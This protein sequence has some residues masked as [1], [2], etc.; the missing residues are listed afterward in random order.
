MGREFSILFQPAPLETLGPQ[1]ILIVD[2][3]ARMRTSLRL[4]L[5]GPERIIED[6]ATGAEALHRLAI[7]DVDLLL[8]DLRLGD[9]PGVDIM[10]TISR[11]QIATMV[12]V[13]SADDNIDSA[14]AALRW[15]VFGYVR[16]PYQPETIRHSVANALS[17]RRLEQSNALMSARLEQSERLHRYLVEQAPDIVY[18]LDDGG[19]FNFINGRVEALLGFG[20]Q[21][22][23]GQH[24]LALVH[25]GDREKAKNAFNERRNGGRASS[26]VELRL[27]CKNPVGGRTAKS[28]EN[29]FITVTL[30]AMGIWSELD[31]EG[32]ARRFIG[33][34]GVARDISDRK[35]AEDLI[36][37]Q[38]HHDLLTGLP[39]RQLFKDHVELAIARAE[40]SGA[41][42]AVMFLDL[43][44]FKLIN[45]TFGH[46][47]G[48]RLLRDLA[49]RLS[50]CRRKGD[51]LARLGGDEFVLLVDDLHG[52]EDVAAIA[53]KLLTEVRRPFDIEGT[54]FRATTS[55]GVAYFPDDGHDV[56]ALIT[57]ADIA[58]YQ[59]KN[60]GKNGY[61]MFTADM[62]T[63]FRKRIG[64]ENDLRRAL[65]DGELELYY[66]PCVSVG[67][68]CVVALEALVRW[69]HPEHGL[70]N[71]TNFVAIAEEVGLIHAIGDF[72]VESAC[73]QLRQWHDTGFKHIRVAINASPRE[74]ERRD[75]VERVLSTMRKFALP[76]N[77]LE[78]EITENTLISDTEGTI[79]RVK[80]LRSA[81]VRIAIDD[82][83]TRYS[84]LNYLQRFPVHTLKIDQCFVRDLQPGRPD[85]PII[86]AIVAI[87]KGF[88]I[89]L[90]SEGVETEFQR[91]ALARMGCDEMQGYLFS[92]PLSP[93]NATD[94]MVGASADDTVP[95]G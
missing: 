91:D 77:A 28:F 74:F 83:G 69:R 20:R 61:Q 53:E 95:L 43:D 64:L 10:E 86:H 38:A 63:A 24:Y 18:T 94:Y 49:A 17:R 48:D 50:Q 75:F 44:R 27:I 14:I 90:V 67:R 78:V 41:N 47:W 52:R 70:L 89:H 37:Y 34:Y 21:E 35:E 65:V 12:I 62:N 73:R 66:Q 85:S 80:Q 29:R 42:L 55:I 25:E 30:S 40:R 19:R 58:M 36:T 1:R 7:G 59:M 81:G 46:L 16:K 9:I 51:T 87:A 79:E 60:V 93:E 45:D 71:P 39:N 15:G 23:I 88:G 11:N 22:L 57:N 8:L 31:D 76:N 84:S 3:E 6:C 92:H 26:N 32:V 82:F 68:G 56:D 4:L 2:D 33:T 13:V 5:Q 54:E 72:V